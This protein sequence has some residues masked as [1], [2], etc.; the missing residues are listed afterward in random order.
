MHF[1]FPWSNEASLPERGRLHALSVCLWDW[2]LP[3]FEISFSFIGLQIGMGHSLEF[4]SL[5]FLCEHSEIFPYL[6]L[7][8]VSSSRL[9]NAKKISKF[10][11]EDKT[12]GNPLLH[13]GFFFFFH[14]NFPIYI[15]KDSLHLFLMLCSYFQN[16]ECKKISTF[17]S[18]DTSNGNTLLHNVFGS[19]VKKATWPAPGIIWVIELILTLLLVD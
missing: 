12:N 1:F 15:Q 10:E 4:L 19:P 13:H 11:R 9:M 5:D 6:V 2:A 18:E 14:E 16:N 8:L 17:E 3:K 7:C